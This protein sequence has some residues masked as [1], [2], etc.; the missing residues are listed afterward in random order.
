MKAKAQAQVRTATITLKDW[1]QD[2]GLL[3]KFRLSSFVV[4][5]SLV[6]YIIAAGSAFALIP[7]LENDTVITEES[8]D[9][10]SSIDLSNRLLKKYNV[11]DYINKNIKD[12]ETNSSKKANSKTNI[13]N[14]SAGCFGIDAEGLAVQMKLVFLRCTKMVC[15]K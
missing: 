5:S 12:F 2:F 14:D 8:I 13:N 15:E 11:L 9:K 6:A 7:F 1:V 4:F 10:L 3:V